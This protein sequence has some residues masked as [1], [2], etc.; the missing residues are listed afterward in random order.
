M[1]DQTIDY[2]RKWHVMAAV[3]ASLF[4]STIDESIVNVALPTLVRELST[5]FPVVQWVVLVYLLTQTTLMLGVGCLG[6]MIGKK[7]IFVTGF[8]V[9]TIGSVLCGFAPSIFWL[10]AF[11]VLQAIGAAMALALGFAITTEAFPPSER[12]KAMGVISTVVSVGIVLGPTLGGLIIEAFSWRWIFFV[13]LPI[14]IIGTVIALRYIP[15]SAPEGRQ[16]FDYGGA[17]S[18]FVSLLSLLL[19]LTLGQQFGFANPLILLLFVTWL[20]FLIIFI[21]IEWRINQP[22]VELGLFKDSIFTVNLVTRFITFIALAG[23]LI[24]LPFYLENV[25]QYSTRQVGL[26]LA[27]VPI[28]LGLA[29]P[30]AGMLADRLGTRPVTIFGLLSLLAGYFALSTLDAQTGTWGYVLRLFPLGLGMG[31]FQT[32]NNSAIMGAVSRGRLGVTSG[33]LSISR[34]L[35]QTSGIA[36]IGALWAGRVIFHHG[37]V[38]PGGAT[39][40]PVSAQIAGL[41]DTFFAVA[42]LT[43]IAL[44]LGIW[45]LVQERRSRQMSAAQAGS[46]V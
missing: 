6:D 34:T 36:L 26:L 22:M 5:T 39:T 30:I 16:R 31:V 38:L 28:F 20:L 29:S 35:G 8:V 1:P 24:L 43:I 4:L 23:T 10:I 13:N 45:G 37:R 25:L 2:S 44:A 11:R 3:G 42:I 14:G 19:A 12:G 40:A 33:L 21:V 18:L 27:V 32:S 46:K 41:Q 7:I 15:P 9:F 17:V